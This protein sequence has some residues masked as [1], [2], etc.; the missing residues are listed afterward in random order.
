MENRFRPVVRVF[1]FAAAC[2]VVIAMAGAPNLVD[3]E[4]ASSA[5]QPT[6][7]TAQTPRPQP[8]MPLYVSFAT[9]DAL[10]VAS[11]SRVL[12]SGGRES[13]PIVAGAWGSPAALAALKAATAAGLIFAAERLRR[14]HP[15]AAL[16]LM[17]AANSGMAAI[18][19]HNYAV[20][21]R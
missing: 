7:S 4:K 8:L 18:V 12:D 5:A 11:T 17:I 15:R 2:V 6:P 16:V 3:D 13:N 9:L 19:A 21:Q 20:A 14:D 10:D 1:L